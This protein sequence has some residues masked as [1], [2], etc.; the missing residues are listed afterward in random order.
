MVFASKSQNNVMILRSGSLFNYAELIPKAFL[1]VLDTKM[2]HI[3]LLRA[4]KIP[5]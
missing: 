2:M 1:S 5:L 4:E 3:R